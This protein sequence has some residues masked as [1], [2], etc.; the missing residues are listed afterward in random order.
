LAPSKGILLS[1]LEGIIDLKNKFIPQ[2]INIC[3]IPNNSQENYLVIQVIG[4]ALIHSCSIH[5]SHIFR[6]YLEQEEVNGD[7]LGRQDQGG[8]LGRRKSWKRRP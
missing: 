5:L 6:K 7:I 8:G 1:Y 4:N 2:V 3:G